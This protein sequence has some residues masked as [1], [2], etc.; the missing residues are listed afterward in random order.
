MFE[1]CKEVFKRE[2]L[3]NF[4]VFEITE[5]EDDDLLKFFVHKCVH[6]LDIFKDN[7]IQNI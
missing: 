6:M 4:D 7:V 2:S 5:L 3:M 1:T